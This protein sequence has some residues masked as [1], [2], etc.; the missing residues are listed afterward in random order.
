MIKLYYAPRT[1]AVRI[2]WLLEEL[3]L[4]YELERVEFRPTAKSFFVQDTPLRK[5]PTIEDN[6]VVMCESGAITQY[7][8]E[9]H[10][11][12]RLA[13]AVGSQE[14]AAYL[15]WMHF[16]ESTAFPPLGIVIWLTLY[17]DDAG[18]HPAV[19]EDARVRAA[20]GFEFVERE[21][22][23]KI[24]LV[25]DEF[26]AADIMM[27]FTLAA[28]RLLGVLDERYPRLNDYM[29]RLEARPAFQRAIAVN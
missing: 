27:G 4:P 1:R 5:L 10:G 29:A 21:M 28:A 15:Q 25:G 8:L 11:E 12:G 16:A 22:G 23:Q 7:I 20:A 6:G 18:Q 3:E 26:C 13:P 24:Y 17:R 19:V 2:L 14:R 9:R